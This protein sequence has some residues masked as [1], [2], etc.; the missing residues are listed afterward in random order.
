MLLTATIA[1]G[2]QAKLLPQQNLAD[3]HVKPANYSGITWLGDNRYALVDDKSP[4]DGFY[5]INI[6]IDDATGKIKSVEPGEFMAAPAKTA[7]EAQARRWADCEDIAYVPHTNTVFITSEA[8][9]Q[10]A[11]Y[12]L[13]VNATGR[14]LNIPAHLSR[15]MQQFNGGFEPLTYHA[16]QQTFWLTTENSLLADSTLNGAQP[17]R[18]VSFNKELM[19]VAEYAY[20]LDK[21]QLK[22]DVKYYTHGISAMTALPDG[23]LLILERELS[24]PPKYLG[25]RCNVKIYAV[26]PTTDNTIAKACD[27]ATLPSEAFLSKKLVA[28]FHTNIKIGSLNYANYEGMCLGPRLAD[29]RQTLL[30]INDS[31]AG[32]GNSL[33]TLKDYIKVILLDLSK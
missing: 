21:P 26:N 32:A 6:Y 12:D 28:S 9:A 13:S 1:L 14:R 31:Q 5:L 22:A 23:R 7:E 8:N 4:L 27:M 20:M 33:C 15:K 2:Q 25:G 24:I 30:L 17:M 10:V 19:P 3:W 29:G 16:Q 11:E 18:I